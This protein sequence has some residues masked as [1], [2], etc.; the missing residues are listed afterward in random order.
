MN[1]MTIVASL[2]FINGFRNKIV[3]KTNYLLNDQWNLVY[4]IFELDENILKFGDKYHESIFLSTISDL[5]TIKD[6]I[7]PHMPNQY[8]TRY[9]SRLGSEDLD[10]FLCKQDGVLMHYSWLFY[11]LYKSPLKSCPIDLKVFI[12]KALMWGPT[13]TLTKSR[14]M[15]Y[16]YVFSKIVKFLKSKGKYQYIIIYA[17]KTNKSAIPFYL[18]LGFKLL[19]SQPKPNIL[20]KIFRKLRSLTT[21][22]KVKQI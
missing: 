18:N 8:D 9:F 11:D 17:D 20:I 1:Q 21:T 16:P 7:Y 3:S 4:M 14:G 22:N 5:P 13:F 19:P 6:Q 15:I 10:C 12:D 2:K